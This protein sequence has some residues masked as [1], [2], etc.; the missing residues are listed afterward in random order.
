MIT[1]LVDVNIA[2]PFSAVIVK[3]C[4]T[5][6]SAAVCRFENDCAVGKVLLVL[7]VQLSTQKQTNPKRRE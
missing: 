5:L 7:F 6:F 1:P 3:V 2:N 4:V